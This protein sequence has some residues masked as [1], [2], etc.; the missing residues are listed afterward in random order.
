MSDSIPS[1]PDI[2][3]FGADWC[4]DCRRSKQFL[5]AHDVPYTY[6]DVEEEDLAELVIELNERSGH[7]PRRRLPTITIDDEILSVPSNE[8]LG[9]RLGL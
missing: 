4:G 2:T 7:G 9:K 1:W 5:E 6:R 8:E 3:V